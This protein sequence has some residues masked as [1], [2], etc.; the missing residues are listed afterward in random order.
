VLELA[1]E[2]AAASGYSVDGGAERSALERIAGE[3]SKTSKLGR[4][5]RGLLGAPR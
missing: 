1:R 4:A 3:M 5:A 2:L